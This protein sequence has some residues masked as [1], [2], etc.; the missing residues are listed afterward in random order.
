MA[1]ATCTV[2]LKARE[3]AHKR[4]LSPKAVVCTFAQ[5]CSGLACDGLDCLMIR[6]SQPLE[7]FDQGQQAL[8]RFYR[9]LGRTAQIRGNGL[10]H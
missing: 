5:A 4:G 2:L 6:S 7:V 8:D 1:E 3:L 9:R 10:H